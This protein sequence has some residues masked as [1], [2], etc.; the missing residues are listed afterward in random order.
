MIISTSRRAQRGIGL[1]E[2]MISLAVFAIG[3]MALIRVFTATYRGIKVSQSNNAAVQIVQARLDELGGMDES[4]LPA[5]NARS[6]GCRSQMGQF[7]P[8]LVEAGQAQCTQYMEA[9]TLK[10]ITEASTG[11][12]RVDTVIR[13]QEGTTQMPGGRVV[14]VSVCWEGTGGAVHQVQSQRLVLPGV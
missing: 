13:D 7:A 10:P 8:V 6:E 1:I 4:L 11:R 3:A 12:F 5:C 9:S 14:V 2:V